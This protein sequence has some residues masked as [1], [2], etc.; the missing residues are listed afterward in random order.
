MKQTTPL[1]AALCSALD[2]LN[3]CNGVGSLGKITL[4]AD[5]S[6]TFEQTPFSCKTRT[7]RF[8]VLTQPGKLTVFALAHRRTVSLA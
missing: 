2:S 1:F 4:C 3:A 8:R 5:G 6:G 7:R